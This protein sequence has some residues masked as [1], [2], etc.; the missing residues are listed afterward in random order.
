MATATEVKPLENYRLWVR[1]SDGIDGI[2]DLSRFAGRSVFTL[3]DD[4][5][6]FQKARVGSSGD[7]VWNDEVDLCPDALYL[8]IT[9][10]KPEDLFPSLGHAAPW[11]CPRT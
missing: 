11:W 4:Y 10:K 7:V 3:W 6:Q 9:N 1:F 8:E 2:V 5:A